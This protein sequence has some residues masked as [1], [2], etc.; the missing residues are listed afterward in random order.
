MNLNGS[1][2]IY[3][4]NKTERSQE[5]NKIL[6]EHNIKL[7]KNPDVLNI[8]LAEEKKSIGIGTV[9]DTIKALGQKPFSHKYKL[10]IIWDADLMTIEAQN[11]LLKVLE[12]PPAYATII[13]CAPTKTSVLPTILSRCKRVEL[14]TKA[15]ETT[16]SDSNELANP[17][18]LSLGE[19]LSWAA[20]TSKEDREVVVEILENFILTMEKS[21]KT[22]PTS[23]NAKVL[24]KLSEIRNDL[25]KTNVN[26]KL[27]LEYLVLSI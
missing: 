7:E 2:L 9:K 3:G 24:A 17:F 1:I 19:R 12:E 15:L 10:L 13:L 8:K 6:D 4:G 5:V 20:E 18:E 26:L 21:L 25:L 23:Q 14:R 27:A 11:T 16:A 22:R